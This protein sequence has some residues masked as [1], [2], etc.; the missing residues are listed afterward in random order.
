LYK[1]GFSFNVGKSAG[2][3][4]VL[5]SVPAPTDASLVLIAAHPEKVERRS[6]ARRG[7]PSVDRREKF[8][9]AQRDRR[10][11]PTELCRKR[12]FDRWHVKMGIMRNRG[13]G[14]NKKSKPKP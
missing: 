3:G 8:I 5:F 14:F 1:S 4:S 13:D 9:A 11:S 10:Q 7:I 6:R 12:E 2:F